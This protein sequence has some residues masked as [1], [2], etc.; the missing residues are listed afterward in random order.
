MTADNEEERPRRGRRVRRTGFSN[1]GLTDTVPTRDLSTGLPSTGSGPGLA[2]EDPPFDALTP[3]AA[4]PPSTP[5]DEAQD[6]LRQTQGSGQE[7]D[8]AETEFTPGQRLRSVSARASNYE[9]EYRLKLLHRMLMRNV[10]LDEIAQ[11][12]GVSVATV[13]R[14][15]RELFGRLRQ[16]ANSLDVELLVGDTL[17]FY[18]EVQAMALR[19]SSMTKTPLPIRLAALRTALAAQNDQHRFL[20]TAGVYEVLRYRVKGS[21][22]TA[23]DL[24]RIMTL[25][26]QLLTTP[27]GEDGVEPL[28]AL[29]GLAFDEEELKLL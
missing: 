29:E 24:A 19:T 7:P 4:A 1:S 14:D 23:G 17:G 20:Q 9:R 8:A 28:S 21:D 22:K 3:P 18:K 6:R 16:A 15:R 12:L 10:P 27:V 2:A 26:K 13:Q 25:T 5:F 11:E